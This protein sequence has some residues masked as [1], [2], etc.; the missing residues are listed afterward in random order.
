ME[1]ENEEDVFDVSVDNGEDLELPPYHHQGPF[2]HHQPEGIYTN[3]SYE[4]HT[5]IP[6][7]FASPKDPVSG[8]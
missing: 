6:I 7:T 2:A 5:Q 4:P 8:I 1:V 3:P